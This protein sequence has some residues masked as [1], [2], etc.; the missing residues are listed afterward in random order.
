MFDRHMAA[1]VS[2]LC[3]GFGGLVGITTVATALALLDVVNMS[4]PIGSMPELSTHYVAGFWL[5]AFC[6]HSVVAG[7]IHGVFSRMIPKEERGITWLRGVGIGCA[8]FVMA[9][10]LLTLQLG[11]LSLLTHAGEA[12]HWLNISVVCGAWLVSVGVCAIISHVIGDFDFG[13]LAR[14]GQRRA[15]TAAKAQRTGGL[16]VLA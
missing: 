6:G 4:S 2:W 8:S 11:G 3:G 12:T 5:F 9:S 13:L 10:T 15:P 7:T 16:P 14:L 1:F